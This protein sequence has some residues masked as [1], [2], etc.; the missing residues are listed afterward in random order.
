MTAIIK[1]SS[2]HGYNS[3][4]TVFGPFASI[5]LAARIVRRLAK[6]DQREQRQKYH[7]AV[8]GGE[9]CSFREWREWTGR[10]IFYNL[11]PFITVADKRCRPDQP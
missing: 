4:I 7:E 9:R 6:V 1:M 3:P 2:S 5:P 11:T 10:H 8:E